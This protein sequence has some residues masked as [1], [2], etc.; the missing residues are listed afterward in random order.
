MPFNSATTSPDA[1]VTASRLT[2]RFADLKADGRR[3]LVAY[4]TAGHPDFASQL[5][6]NAIQRIQAEFSL[7]AQ[8]QKTMDAYR[9]AFLFHQS[10]KR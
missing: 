1:A 5:A 6:R 7:E 2:R 3:A 9:K 10:L 8:F 4:L